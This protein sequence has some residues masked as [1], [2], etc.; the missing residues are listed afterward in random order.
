MN[1][2]ADGYRTDIGYTYGYHPELNPLRLRLAFLNAG[3]KVPTIASACELGFGQGI[4]I[5]IHA[6]A[7]PVHW[8]GTDIN[9]DHA[10]F[11][12]QLAA[13]SGAELGLFDNSFAEFAARPDLPAFDYIGLHGVWSWISDRNRAAIVSFVERKLRPGGVLYV[14]YNALPGWAAFV[15]VRHLLVEHANRAGGEGRDIADRIDDAVNFLARLLATETAFARENPRILPSVKFLE[16]SDRRYLAHEYFNRDWQPMHFATVADW[17]APAKLRYACSADFADHVD[18]LSLSAAQRSL[19]EEIREP[20]LR[21]SVRDLIANPLFRR[22][23]W[24]KGVEP[25]SAADRAEALRRERVIFVEHAG[26]LPFELRAALALREAEPGDAVSAAILEILGDRKAWSVGEIERAL[27]P[28]DV[29]LDRIADMLFLIANCGLIQAAQDDAV[30]AR[31]RSRTD[32]LNAWSIDR[33]RVGRAMPDL[34]SPVTGGGI[35]VGRIE[36]LFLFALRHGKTR[37]EEWAHEASKFVTT[38]QAAVDLTGQA[39]RFAEKRLPTL[40]A[41]QIV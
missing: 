10:A 39:Q 28:R 29:S 25:I 17:L 3:L 36:Q 19:L 31:V 11:A 24:A 40:R 33:A 14:G 37:P 20:R 27:K 6:A 8:H 1:D 13:A 41:L 2:A 34:A 32:R 22:D 12:R 38:G 5:A 21:E 7:S 15:P 4:S 23:Y 9:P 26:E 18:A 35:A 16:E 30:S